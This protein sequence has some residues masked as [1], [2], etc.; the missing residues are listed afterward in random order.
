M[1]RPQKPKKKN[2]SDQILSFQEIGQFHFKIHDELK[3][4]RRE[5]KEQKLGR[6]DRLLSS[7]AVK[8]SATRPVRRDRGHNY[9]ENIV[10]PVG[11]TSFCPLL[12][13]RS[14][15]NEWPTEMENNLPR[16]ERMRPIL[17]R[18]LLSARWLV[19]YASISSFSLPLSFSSSFPSNR[20]VSFLSNVSLPTLF[21]CFSFVKDLFHFFF[22]FILFVKILFFSC[23]VKIYGWMLF[24]C[25]FCLLFFNFWKRFFLW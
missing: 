10:H 24:H 8:S 20:V 7:R 13:T 9:N 2:Q 16:E 14:L 4:G 18:I 19:V 17:F 21:S 5:A 12:S 22:Y 6:F 1:L 3:W 25:F 23:E 15:P 11:S